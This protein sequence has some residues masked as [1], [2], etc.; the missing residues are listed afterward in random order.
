MRRYFSK[1]KDESKKEDK[2][3]HEKAFV[4]FLFWNDIG[5]RGI[6]YEE[7]YLRRIVLNKM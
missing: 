6:Q 1:S 5:K 7:S 3:G 2:V 4:D